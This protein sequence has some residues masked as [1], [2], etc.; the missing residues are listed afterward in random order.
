MR[1]VPFWGDAKNNDYMDGCIRDELQARRAYRYTLTQSERHGLVADWVVYP[2]TRVR[3]E[4]EPA[5]KRAMELNAFL[6]GVP[7]PRYDRK[8]HSQGH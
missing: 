8:R 5:I 1:I 2:D 3:V 7:Y 4:L 6:T